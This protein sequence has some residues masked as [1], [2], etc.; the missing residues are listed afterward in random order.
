ML[1]SHAV[2]SLST[3]FQVVRCETK[4]QQLVHGAKDAPMVPVERVRPLALGILIRYMETL[5]EISASSLVKVHQAAIPP[6]LVQLL[7]QV[8]EAESFRTGQ[9]LRLLHGLQVQD[10]Q[11]GPESHAEL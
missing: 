11:Q 4:V 10:G 3:R 8:M 9:W 7:V 2:P 1:T 5:Q 6:D